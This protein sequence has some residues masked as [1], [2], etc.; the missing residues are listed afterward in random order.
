MEIK[1]DIDDGDAHVL[2]IYMN[3]VIKA[4][5]LNQKQSGNTLLPKVF[6]DFLEQAGEQMSL[7]FDAMYPGGM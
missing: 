2:M 7:N 5:S 6:T 1:I 3:Q 4:Q